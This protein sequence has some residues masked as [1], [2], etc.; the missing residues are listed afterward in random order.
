M[1]CRTTERRQMIL[2][3]AKTVFLER[4]Y[5]AS[6]M[7]EVAVRAGGS[8]QTLYGYFSTKDELFAAAMVQ[9]GE[10]LI[11]PLY[12]NLHAD[13]H[14]PSA[15]SRFAIGFLRFA[16]TPEFLAFRRIVYGE[17]A[18]SNLGQLFFENGPKRGWAKMA[19]EFEAA[20]GQGR[21]R[22]SDPWRAVT[23]FH[24][25]CEAGPLQRLI[26]GAIDAVSDAEL[27]ETAQAAVEIFARAY[28]LGRL[29]D[30]RPG[31]RPGVN[32]EC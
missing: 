26:E 4:G 31:D 22:Q 29:D 21:M 14:L 20:M 18:K 10:A 11:D 12:E 1:R 3:A 23:H 25:L 16:V 8:K 13:Q 5:T 19:T 6:S 27:V 15:L 9:K 2:D 28:E 7:S 32:A 17:G 24:A 30:A